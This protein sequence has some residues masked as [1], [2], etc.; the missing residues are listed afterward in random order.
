[1]QISSW[2]LKSEW[3][4]SKYQNIYIYIYIR[5]FNLWGTGCEECNSRASGWES[6]PRR[7]V[8]YNPTCWKAWIF[9]V[10]MIKKGLKKT[11]KFTFVKLTENR[12]INIALHSTKTLRRYSNIATLQHF[13]LYSKPLYSSEDWKLSLKIGSELKFPAFFRYF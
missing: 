13:R 6:I 9:R 8:N 3:D 4:I 5:I 11:W 2:I 7:Q 12:V 10:S 1:M